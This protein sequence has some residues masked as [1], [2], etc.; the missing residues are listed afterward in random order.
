M[1]S[2]GEPQA[3]I[4]STLIRIHDEQDRELD[5]TG[6]NLTRQGEHGNA[7]ATPARGRSYMIAIRTSSSSERGAQRIATR[8][9]PEP[10]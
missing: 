6:K 8:G 5:I 10:L 9:A 3:T 4:A 7:R 1:S 2:E